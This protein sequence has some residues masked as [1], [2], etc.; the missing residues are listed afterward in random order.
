MSG[1]PKAAFF[2]GCAT[3]LAVTASYAAVP[4]FDVVRLPKP[5]PA[6]STD[7]PVFNESAAAGIANGD[8]AP[9]PHARPSIEAKP[10][11]ANWAEGAASHFEAASSEQKRRAH[12]KPVTLAAETA[13]TAMDDQSASAIAA[14]DALAPLPRPRP[15][16]NTHELAMVAPP[17][18]EP[19]LP[20]LVAP[21]DAGCIGRIRALGVEFTEEPPLDPAGNC[22][23]PH[24]LKVTSLGSGVSIGPATILNCAET[25]SLALWMKD[26]VVP[27]AN[28]LLGSAPNRIT[29]DSAYVCRTRYNDPHQK[30]SEHAHANA[31]DIAAFSFADRKAVEVGRTEA[32][33]SEG[34]FEAEI[35]KGACEYF[36]TVLGPGSNAAHATHFHLDMQFRRGGYRLCELGAP[37]TVASPAP[38]KTK[39]E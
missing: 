28:R 8:S 37:V 26:V 29:Q 4:A 23:V 3:C 30:I 19:L 20:G 7:A 32:T 16:G 35:R 36:K 18:V 5:R 24:P 6:L 21:E 9:V 11:I 14:I 2:I 31:L 17:N 39:R 22:S 27:S 25:E 34:K 10:E 38:A 15:E 13:A 33:S 12:G 1:M